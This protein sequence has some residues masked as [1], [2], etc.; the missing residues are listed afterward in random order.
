MQ[1]L[2]WQKLEEK[3]SYHCRIF[4]ISKQRSRS[5]RDGREHEFD[6]LYSPDWVN[7]AAVTPAG[8]L[9]LIRQYR[10]GSGAITTEIPGGMLDQGESPLDAAK[11]E[12][13]EETG[14]STDHWEQ[15][16]MVEPNPAFQ[17][18]RTYTFLARDAIRTEAQHLDANEDIEVFEHPLGNVWSLVDGG[19]IKHALVLCAILHLVRHGDLALPGM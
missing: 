14:Y 3:E 7:V 16:G 13:S 19:E 18:N 2:G 15:I 1:A 17:T 8:K 10:H 12:L 9:V 5:L 11:R 6:L 4:S